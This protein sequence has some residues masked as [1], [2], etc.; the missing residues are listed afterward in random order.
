[1]KAKLLIAVLVLAIAGA[2]IEWALSARGW[3][4]PEAVRP[5][6]T[7]TLTWTG[8][9]GALSYN[10]YR[11]QTSAVYGP[12]LATGVSSTAYID[13]TVVPGQTYFYAVTAV[14][15]AGESGKSIEKKAIIPN[16]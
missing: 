15:A 4:T 5:A 7:V 16:P 9:A 8:S 6:H 13:T 11:S 2:L 3:R 1:V 14:N 10:I 12:P